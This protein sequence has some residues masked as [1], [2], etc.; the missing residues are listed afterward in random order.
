MAP[1]R[2]AQADP[3]EHLRYSERQML[4]RALDPKNAPALDGVAG[5]VLRLARERAAAVRTPEGS[6]V[7]RAV[8][9]L[10][11]RISRTYVGDLEG[12]ARDV[13]AVRTS[14]GP[15]LT[16]EQARALMWCSEVIAT[17]IEPDGHPKAPPLELLA[18]ANES[19]RAFLASG[20]EDG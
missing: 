20:G 1:D 3:R 11:A 6:E 14:E 18:A 2:P 9:V 19:L 12:L 15:D 13:L 10:E 5:I 8:E 4:D 17:G 16:R 7:E